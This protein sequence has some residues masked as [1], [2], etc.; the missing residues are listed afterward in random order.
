MDFFQLRAKQGCFVYGAETAFLVVS[1]RFHNYVVRLEGFLQ[2]RSHCLTVMARSWHK[3]TVKHT[4][5]LLCFLIAPYTAPI[6]GHFRN[7]P[8][9]HGFNFNRKYI[10]KVPLKNFWI[11][12]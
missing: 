10:L 7:V 11:K 8:I 3:D 2:L 4:L 9:R 6:N 1:K 12:P 5:R